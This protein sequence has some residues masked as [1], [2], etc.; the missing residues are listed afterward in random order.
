[1]NY[2]EHAFSVEQLI[3][4]TKNNCRLEIKIE[5]RKKE[6]YTFSNVRKR[7]HFCQVVQQL[8]NLHSPSEELQQISIFIGTW[9]MG[10][11]LCFIWIYISQYY[12]LT[13]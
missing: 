5:G 4:C 1:M 12:A 8:K 7:E 11:N 3:K 2:N 10:K 6:S 13:D 9:N